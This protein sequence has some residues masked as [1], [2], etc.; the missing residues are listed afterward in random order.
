MP[1]APLAQ[2]QGQGRYVLHHINPIQ[3]GGG[4]YDLDNLVVVTP[5][6]HKEIL[7]G[8]YHFGG[9]WAFPGRSDGQWQ[10]SRVK[11]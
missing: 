9:G 2:H 5:Q 11:N 6:Y 7:D 8:G 4:V 10:G 3:H 1:F